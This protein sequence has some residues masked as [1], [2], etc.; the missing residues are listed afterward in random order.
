M[1]RSLK[2]NRHT[3]KMQPDSKH[4]YKCHCKWCID[5]RTRYTRIADDLLESNL[6]DIGNS[7][8]RRGR[9]RVVRLN[10]EDIKPLEQT[11]RACPKQVFIDLT[12]A[13]QKIKLK[14][15]QCCDGPTW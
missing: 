10:I 13:K 14:L 9:L 7:F 1:S 3:F 6:K 8:D 15:K 4:N 5:S 11:T 2:L 12:E